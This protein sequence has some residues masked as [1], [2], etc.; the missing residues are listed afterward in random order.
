MGKKIQ[1]ES[2]NLNSKSVFITFIN[3]HFQKIISSILYKYSK[4][5]EHPVYFFQ[6]QAGIHGKI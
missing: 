3:R 1:D 4:K 6:N 2:L 5:E